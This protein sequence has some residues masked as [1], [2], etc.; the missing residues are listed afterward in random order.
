MVSEGITNTYAAAIGAS[1]WH[2]KGNISGTLCVQEPLVTELRN[3]RCC[4]ENRGNADLCS[5]FR[6]RFPAT[7]SGFLAKYYS[8]KIFW[9]RK[10]LDVTSSWTL[11]CRRGHPSSPGPPLLCLFQR[12]L[13]FLRKFDQII[14]KWQMFLY[15]S[16]SLC[17][18]DSPSLKRAG[19][20]STCPDKRLWNFSNLIRSMEASLSA[21]PLLLA[22]MQWR[23]DKSLPGLIT[24]GKKSF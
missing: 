1:L 11:H 6:N 5:T 12:T 22:A 10:W 7:W 20:S 23:Q 9:R 24:N 4:V 17:H 16:G 13:I 8:C 2:H 21:R 18:Q 19:A 14:C 3:L 15:I